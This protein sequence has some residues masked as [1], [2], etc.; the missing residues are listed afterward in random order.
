MSL[1]ETDLNKLYVPRR[2]SVFDYPLNENDILP[3]V[4]GDLTVSSGIQGGSWVLPCIDTSNHVY[5]FADHPVLSVA[6]GNSV[7]IYADG[8]LAAPGYYVFNEADTAY[9]S[10]AT[11]TFTSAQG[12]KRISA[13]GKGK[14]DPNYSQN[15]LYNL[16]DIAEDF[17]TGQNNYDPEMFEPLAKVRARSAFVGE[18][19]QT[20]GVIDQEINVWTLL[21]EMMGSFLGSVY[22]NSTGKLVFEVDTNQIPDSQAPI[23]PISDIRFKSAEQRLDD[24][25]NKITVKY[26]FNFVVRDF[27][28]EVS[29]S[30]TLSRDIYGDRSLTLFSRWCADQASAANVADILLRK[31]N[32]PTWRISFQDMTLK[33]AHLDV[34]DF[35]VAAFPY[36]YG[37]DKKTMINQICKIVENRPKVNQGQVEFTVLDTDQYMTDQYGNRDMIRY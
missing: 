10:I 9:G 26:K 19:Y 34:G 27:I 6:D 18:S 5:C 21:K 24:V 17:L 22:K 30:D 31:F 32:H 25:V 2:A 15:L 8:E 14:A 29:N 3:V 11:V 36:I 33:R 1:Y 37:G 7:S 35:V 16:I 20:A 28:S 13:R 12:S 23:I 4:Y